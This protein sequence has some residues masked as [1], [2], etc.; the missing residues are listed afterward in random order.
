MK[1]ILV[2][3][4]VEQKHRQYLEDTAARILC[5]E[6]RRTWIRKWPNRR[7]LYWEML[8]QSI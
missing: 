7:R 1:E 3:I 6:H 4:P 2:T 5:T 8:S